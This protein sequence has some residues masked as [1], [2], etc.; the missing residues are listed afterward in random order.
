MRERRGLAYRVRTGIDTFLDAGTLATHCGIEHENLKETL[1]VILSEYR[2]ISTEPVSAEE[3]KRA[4]ENIKGG[5]ALG[6]EGSDEVVEYLVGQEILENR[7]VLP[8]DKMKAIDRVTVE[9]VLRVAKDIFQDK[10]LNLAIISPS[11]KKSELSRL[12]HL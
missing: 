1:R 4:K 11:A 12:L 5:M 6:L 8:A 9:D 10:K 2:K 3:L 7:I